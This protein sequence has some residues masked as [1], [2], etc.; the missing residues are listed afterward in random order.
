LD[1]EIDVADAPVEEQIPHGSSHQIQR[2]TLFDG[3]PA[4]RLDPPAQRRRELAQVRRL[5]KIRPR[6]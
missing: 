3:Q 4:R 5:R 6:L 1:R 2:Q